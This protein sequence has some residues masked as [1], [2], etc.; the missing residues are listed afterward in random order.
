MDKFN[1]SQTSTA[2]TTAGYRDISALHSLFRFFEM[3]HMTIVPR[4]IFF[5][6]SCLVL[7]SVKPAFSG[8]PLIL[9]E[10]QIVEGH[11]ARFVLGHGNL[12]AGEKLAGLIHLPPGCADPSLWAAESE[13]LKIQ[14]LPF[15][16]GAI[17]GLQVHLESQAEDTSGTIILEGP[18]P[19]LFQSREVALK[20]AYR[21]VFLNSDSP[22]LVSRQREKTSQQSPQYSGDFRVQYGAGDQILSIRPSL[23]GAASL[24]PAS[25]RLVH[26]GSS[27]SIGGSIGGNLWFYAPYNDTLTDDSD[28]V[29]LTLDSSDPSVEMAARPAFQTLSPEQSEVAIDRSRSYE[30]NN[31]YRRAMSTGIGRRFA[32]HWLAYPQAAGLDR[33]ETQQLPFFDVLSSPEISARVEIFGDNQ[34]DGI[35]PDHHADLQIEGI[36]LPRAEWEGSRLHIVNETVALPSTT[37][38]PGVSLVH[39]VA[40]DSP[41]AQ[42]GLDMQLLD[43]VVLRWNGFPRAEEGLRGSLSVPYSEN[44]RRVTMGGFPAGTTSSDLIVLDVT[45]PNTPVRIT[46]PPTFTDSSGTVAVEF[47]A[48]Q[49]AS[50]FWIQLKSDFAQPDQAV[51]TETLPSPAK[52][53]NVIEALYIRPEPYADEIAPLLASRNEAA[54]GFS[55]QAA[56]NAFNGG[57]KSPEAIRDAIRWLLENSAQTA[58]IPRVVLIGA[59]SLDPRNYLE[60]PQAPE[61]PPFIQA[62]IVI[63]GK[64]LE[65]T[66]D[67]EYALLFGND[68]IPDAALGRIPA[69]NSDQLTTAINRQLAYDQAGSTLINPSRQGIFVADE[70]AQFA[71]DQNRWINRWEQTG[72]P[73]F[74]I[75]LDP[76]TQSADFADLQNQL[77]AGTGAAFVL[78]TGHG[79]TD[80]W[81]GLK[82]LASEDVPTIDT[83][84]KWPII[85]TFTCLNGYYAA[86]GDEPCLAEEWLFA[87]ENRGAIAN[88]A[89]AGVDQY[90]E[91]SLF[92]E[93]FMNQFIYSPGEAPETIG[94]V[95]FLAQVDFATDHPELDTTIREYNLFGDPATAL[96]L[97]QETASEE[98]WMIY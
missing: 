56:Y 32:Y 20:Q 43:R 27:L 89:P 87:D 8:N 90:F 52:T 46:N 93:A 95:L 35:S 47:E 26:R 77:E 75:D 92:N 98:N 57:Q 14:I 70:G 39:S 69:E 30:E 64:N 37:P 6:A 86:P 78:Y 4:F 21:S 88:I 16:M 13:G 49:E 9:E 36:A 55:P 18:V 19:E 33:T 81:S 28:S 50:N 61:V 34:T 17:E 25:T 5:F 71:P 23:L 85:A 66:V 59:G 73:A 74:R 44:P 42:S 53:S 58:P 84:G 1:Q 67:Y 94:D 76:A 40:D 97:E 51:P 10:A 80:R 79:N 83:N 65:N 60:L 24:D 29:F 38:A 31:V 82:F 2:P 12:A 96:Y 11:P 72:R 45:V 7:V 48:A 63:N 62:G 22:I 91:Q 15:R 68:D 54:Y 41:T 3:V